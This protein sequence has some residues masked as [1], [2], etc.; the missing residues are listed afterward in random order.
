MTPSPSLFLSVAGLELALSPS[1][2]GSISSLESIGEGRRTAVL[3]K[4]NSSAENVLEAASFPL[5]PFV[6]RIRGGQFTFR[7]RD[8]RLA[9]NMAGDP[10]PLHGQ[11]WLAP[12][13]VDEAAASS[14]T[15]SFDHQPANAVG[16][17]RRA[18]L[19]LM[20]VACRSAFLPQP[21]DTPMRAAWPT[22]YFHCRSETR[23][24]T[25]VTECGPR[26]A[27]ASA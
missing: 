12:W 4:C 13:Q 14:A 25:K 15:L 18:A 16:I 5:V 8:I 26:R 24:D 6:N 10:S 20:P 22:S 11:G 2:G 19:A 21:S 1:T 3:R 27:C 23:I 17:S 9:P 7:G